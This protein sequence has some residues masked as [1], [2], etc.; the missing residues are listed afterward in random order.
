MPRKKKIIRDWTEL[1]DDLE[2][3][4]AMPCKPTRN[5]L[6]PDTVI[7]ENK[8]VK[9]N[10]EEVQ[11]QND[12]Y[13]QEVKDLNTKK[14]KFRDSLYDEVIEKI[15]DETDL[16]KDK[17]ESIWFYAYGK[18]HHYGIHSVVDT[19]RELIDLFNDVLK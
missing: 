15:A 6:K 19:V 8:S 11:R 13:E 16:P 17:V 2:K 5:R 10:R 1:I 18:S 3:M 7:D 9:W 12:L 4:C 14:N